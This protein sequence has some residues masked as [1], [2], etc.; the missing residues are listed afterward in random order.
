MRRPL[1]DIIH[2]GT[3]QSERRVSDAFASV[4]LGD[5]LE[6]SSLGVPLERLRGRSVLLA[7]ENQL[8]AV[9]ALVQLDGLAS[10]LVLCPPGLPADHVAA[11]SRVAAVDLV[12]SDLTAVKLGVA[13]ER[14]ISCGTDLVDLDVQ[15][16]RDRETEWLLLTS[17][18]SGVPK[19]V[20]HILSTLAG[21][22]KP[23][24]NDDRP[25]VWSTFYDVRRY[26]GL[27][28]VLRALVAGGSLVLSSMGEALGDF[29]AR[30]GR[31]GVT[32]MSGTP[33]H[34][35]R[36]LMSPAIHRIAPRYVRLSGEIADQAI[37]D[38]LQTCFGDAAVAHA[39]ASTE[40][41]VAFEVDDGREGFPAAFVGREGL[42]EMKVEDGSLRIRSPRTA[43]RYLGDQ[44]NL[45][46]NH[47]FVDTGDMVERRRDRY[48]F[49]GRRGGIINVGGMKVHPEEVEAVI[50]AH[51]QVQMSLVK[52][53]RSPIT[54]AIVV[55]E[56]L[57][58]LQSGQA[59][60]DGELLKGEIIA[61]CRSALARHKVP[62]AISLVASLD[63][64]AS[65][66]L[67][68]PVA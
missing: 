40:A 47:G 62:A 8:A 56:V 21:A 3:R 5:L 44:D 33:S 11:I 37:L 10:R 65:G 15:P 41:G 58:R 43:L 20:V 4:A 19:I 13:P 24:G 64:A 51:P 46:D 30:A 66:K 16:R 57:V 38:A 18:T 2:A 27:Q 45:A 39:F 32:H 6:R 28:I 12:I 50:N 68:R 1:H 61:A 53:R 35:R 60:L 17:G 55:A 59:A 29:L 34:W 7:T 54:G 14:F 63:V 67:A 49:V 22:M 25:L 36:A 48:V 23:G 26:G 9:L 52:A 42:V 31:C